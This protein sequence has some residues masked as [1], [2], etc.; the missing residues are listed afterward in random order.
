MATLTI[1]EPPTQP[2][3][4]QQLES[5][6]TIGDW[7]KAG[8]SKQSDYAS[9]FFPNSFSIVQGGL[10]SHMGASNVGAD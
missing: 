8:E 2:N 10:R 1:E 6:Y 9:F 7:V 4:T 5:G 3:A